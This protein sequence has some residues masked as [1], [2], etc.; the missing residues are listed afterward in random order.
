MSSKSLGKRPERTSFTSMDLS[1]HAAEAAAEVARLEEAA[2]AATE[3]ARL[4]EAAAAAAAADGF[5][6]SP[7]PSSKCN[8]TT[9]IPPPDSQIQVPRVPLGK[10]LVDKWIGVLNNKGNIDSDPDL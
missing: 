2:Q 4:A 8:K 1:N 9:H 10:K 6:S 5:E 3:V 7:E